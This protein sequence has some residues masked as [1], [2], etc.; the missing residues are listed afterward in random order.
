[1][2]PLQLSYC[3]WLQLGLALQS[4]LEPTI[5]IFYVGDFRAIMP[6]GK[7]CTGQPVP[8]LKILLLEMTQRDWISPTLFTRCSLI[9]GFPSLLSMRER[10]WRIWK[11]SRLVNK[12]VSPL[13]CSGIYF[14]VITGP[15]LADSKLKF[16]TLQ[17]KGD[18]S[19][20]K[21]TPAVM[22]LKVDIL[23]HLYH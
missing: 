2:P 20:C 13:G 19:G 17:N 11:S 5:V 15:C 18:W 9:I 6:T 4:Q 22:G 10:F 12:L 1:M 7:S 14:T 21:S 16:A 3:H 23:G 8:G